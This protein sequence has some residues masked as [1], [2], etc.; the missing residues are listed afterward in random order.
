MV[1]RPLFYAL[2][3]GRISLKLASIKL[4]RNANKCKSVMDYVNLASDIFTTFPFKPWSISPAQVKEEIAK[5]LEILTKHKLKSMLEI[6]TAKGGTLFLFTK[7]SS[8]DAVIISVDLPSGPFGGGYPEWRTQL[9]KSFAI[10]NQ[11]INLIR[12]NSHDFSTLKMVEKVLK[13]RKLDFLFID[14]DHRYDGVKRDFEMYSR[15]VRKGGLVAFHDICYHPPE[16]GCEVHKL[17]NEIKNRYRHEEI[18]KNPQQGW[19]GIG[20]LYV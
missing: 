7:F 13:G 6:G 4:N 16:T 8:P 15:L 20:V 14:G 17:W 10:Q 11:K 12:E 9:Y 1:L 19:A 18:V 3:T 5:L 2:I